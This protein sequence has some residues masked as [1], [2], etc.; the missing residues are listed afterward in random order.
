MNRSERERER[1][2]FVEKD[3]KRGKDTRKNP[4]HKQK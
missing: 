4:I 3:G 2:D 1:K